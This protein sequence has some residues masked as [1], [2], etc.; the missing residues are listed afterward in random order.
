[1]LE[2]R[3]ITL[4]CAARDWSAASHDD[5][6]SRHRGDH[7]LR[8]FLTDASLDHCYA[9]A[10]VLDRA[11]DRPRGAPGAGPH[12]L[13][14][15][16]VRRP[17]GLRAWLW[18]DTGE[19]DQ[20]WKGLKIDWMIAEG[21]RRHGHPSDLQVSHADILHD[22]Y[23]KWLPVKDDYRALA[24]AHDDTWIM[25]ASEAVVIAV[26]EAQSHRGELIAVDIDK[27]SASVAQDFSVKVDVVEDLAERWIIVERL[28]DNRKPV[29]YTVAYAMADA[30][31]DGIDDEDVTEIFQKTTILDGAYTIDPALVYAWSAIV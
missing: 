27:V 1:M 10:N 28:A 11:R 21:P 26:R 8:R 23:D 5:V 25:R 12:V 17:A 15:F 13:G 29:A 18:R 14:N 3:R 22:P 19:L 4:A 6:V 2:Y 20:A 9:G 30:A 7:L 24:M 31:F 16:H